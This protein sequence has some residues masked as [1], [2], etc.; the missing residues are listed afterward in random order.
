V[1]ACFLGAALMWLRYVA[2]EAPLPT[3]STNA[4][5]QHHYR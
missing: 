4:P 2:H 5:A 3:Y 1:A